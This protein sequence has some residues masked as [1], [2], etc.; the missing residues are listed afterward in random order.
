VTTRGGTRSEQLSP[1]V[2]WQSNRGLPLYI[3]QLFSAI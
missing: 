3:F 1:D 2:A